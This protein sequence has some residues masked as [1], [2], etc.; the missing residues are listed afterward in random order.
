MA[1]ETHF[2][3]NLHAVYAND[4]KCPR[5]VILGFMATV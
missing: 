3:L 1:I 2:G 5:I 4:L